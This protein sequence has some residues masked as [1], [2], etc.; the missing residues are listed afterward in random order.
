MR[1][2]LRTI[3]DRL[4]PVSNAVARVV[5]D[6]ST[7]VYRS[8]LMHTELYWL[9]VSERVEYRCQYNQAPRYLMDHCSPVS[10]V[11]FRQ[12]LRPATSHT[13]SVHPRYRL[14]TSTAVG[15]DCLKLCPKTR[16]IP[17]L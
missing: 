4:Q 10:D 2:S 6:I 16:G 17:N 1:Y 5:S 11:V 8:Q 14:S 3:I 12:R 9:N 7:V 13:L 15:S